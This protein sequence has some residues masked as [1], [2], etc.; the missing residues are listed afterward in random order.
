MLPAERR[1]GHEEL[2]PT[3]PSEAEK[4]CSARYHNSHL[5]KLISNRSLTVAALIGAPRPVT[6]NAEA[7]AG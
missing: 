3:A 7:C 2:K 1:G 6:P 5:E 4:Y